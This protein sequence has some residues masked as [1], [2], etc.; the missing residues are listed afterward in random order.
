MSPRSKESFGSVSVVV[1]TLVMCVA[2]ESVDV[3]IVASD[4]VD[5]PITI[6]FGT[7]VTLLA[8]TAT[9]L[10][11]AAALLARAVLK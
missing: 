1:V 8:A 7:V 5:E 4:A 10:T 2:V 3:L 9:L 6:T 11:T